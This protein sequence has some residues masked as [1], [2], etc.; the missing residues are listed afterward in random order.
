MKSLPPA[1]PFL[2]AFAPIVGLFADNYHEVLPLDLVR[3]VVA[4]AAFVLV[5]YVF[6][7]LIVR[8]IRKSA[9]L[10]A[11]L[12]VV[13]IATVLSATS[14]LMRFCAR[15]PIFSPGWRSALPDT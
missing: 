10:T 7:Y 9:F 6:N 8:D 15:G 1:Y 14:C 12:V 11:L 5:T 4:G 3:P 2:F 13:V